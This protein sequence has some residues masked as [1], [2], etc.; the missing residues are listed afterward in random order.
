MVP[1]IKENLNFPEANGKYLYEM[2]DGKIQ[3]FH[4]DL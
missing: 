1:F 3:L 4:L 2:P